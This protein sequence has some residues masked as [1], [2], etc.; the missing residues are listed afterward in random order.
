MYANP[1]NVASYLCRSS[2]IPLARPDKWDPAPSPSLAQ[3]SAHLHV[4]S[5]LE[6]EA[7]TLTPDDVPSQK[8]MQMD[9]EG[10]LRPHSAREVHPYARSRIYDLRRYTD[11]NMWG[12]FMDDGSG[13]VDWEKVQAIMIDLAYNERIH[14]E[15]RPQRSAVLPSEEVDAVLGGMIAMSIVRISTDVAYPGANH[16]CFGGI[17]ANSFMSVP[18]KGKITPPPHPS[19]DALDPYGVTGTWMRIVCFLDYNDLYA[20]N[21]ESGDI[22]SSVERDPVYTRE[23]Y[24]KIK[25]RLWVT[26]IEEQSED[27]ENCGGDATYCGEDEKTTA[28][29]GPVVHFQGTSRSLFMSW[30]PNANSKIRGAFRFRFSHIPSTF[31]FSILL[32]SWSASSNPTP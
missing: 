12:P 19:L 15:R 9:D 2:L 29:E 5:G 18:I 1:Q 4:L 22:P 11:A 14:I 8:V 28:R 31:S 30:D 16:R 17:A 13:R 3:L 26:K 27:G 6:L 25:L 7:P 23:A 24:R 21:F 10:V 20:F 32:L